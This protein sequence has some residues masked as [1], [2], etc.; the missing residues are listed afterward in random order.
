VAI[1][2]FAILYACRRAGIGGQAMEQAESYALYACA[3]G[4]ALA[5]VT[6]LLVWGQAQ[7]TL[8]GQSFRL[9][10]AHL[11]IGVGI[12]VL[13]AIPAVAHA[14]AHWRGMRRP[15]PLVF[16]GIAILA[17]VGAL[18]QGYLGGRMTYAQAVGIDEGG[19]LTQ[20][21]VGAERLNL[22]L[23]QGVPDARAGQEAFGTSGLGCA[24]CHGDQAQGARGPQLAGGVDLARFRRVHEHGLFP[25][26]IVTDRDFAAI[27]AWLRTLQPRGGEAGG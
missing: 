18:V 27:D 14:N 22:E 4:V 5:G 2:L 13:V 6:G 17:T 24:S 3:I 8:R 25:K 23:A 19:Q 15:A 21:A 9:G 16:G 1:P 10:T 26:K 20:S 11:W 12:A 7:T